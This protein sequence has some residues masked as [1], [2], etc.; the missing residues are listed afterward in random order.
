MEQSCEIS[1]EDDIDQDLN[2]LAAVE[3]TF[4]IWVTR[5]EQTIESL[6]TIATYIDSFT[7]KTSWVKAIGSG[8]GV[9]GGGLTVIG[10]ALTIATGGAAAIP[11]LLGTYINLIRQNISSQ[12]ISIK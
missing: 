9:L 11:I 6:E 3:E 5:R 8:T 4:E 1:K 7:K 2:E 10:G 12:N